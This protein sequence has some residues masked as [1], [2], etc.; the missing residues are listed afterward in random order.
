MKGMLVKVI[1]AVA[2]EIAL[3]A[4]VFAIA[5]TVVTPAA[6]GCT[7]PYEILG[8][9]LC[10]T[11][12]RRPCVT[13]PVFL[14]R[15]LVLGSHQRILGLVLVQVV[16]LVA[17]LLTLVATLLADAPTAVLIAPTRREPV[18]KVWSRALLCTGC[19]SLLTSCCLGGFTLCVLGNE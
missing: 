8:F 17:G 10:T 18:T 2:L 19:K 5:S 3:V 7:S 1:V 13:D 4:N 15:A 11:G 12:L 16:V 14:S 9:A 6:T